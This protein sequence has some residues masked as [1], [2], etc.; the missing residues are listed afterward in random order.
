M[1]LLHEFFQKTEEEWTISTHFMGSLLCWCKI[2]TRTWQERKTMGQYF[3]EYRYNLQQSIAN[4]IWEHIK[5]IIYIHHDQ[6][7]LMQSWFLH[8]KICVMCVCL[9]AVCSV[10]SDSLWSHGSPPGFSVHGIFLGKTTGVSNHFL[11]Q[12]I[13]LAQ[14]SNPHLLHW[15]VNSL[16][17]SHLGSPICNNKEQN[18]TLSSE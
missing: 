2:Q 14:G 9:C 10:V 5:R 7:E 16:P 11:L 13:F 3:Y 6:V 17:L 15:W 8:L 12:G 4:Q 1:P 18:L